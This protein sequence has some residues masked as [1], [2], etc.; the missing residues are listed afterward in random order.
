[1]RVSVQGRPRVTDSV[2][3]RPPRTVLGTVGETMRKASKIVYDDR[4]R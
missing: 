4:L 3:R 2:R 1:M